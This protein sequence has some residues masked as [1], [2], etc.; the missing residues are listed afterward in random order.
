MDEELLDPK[1]LESE[2][3]R[4]CGGEEGGHIPFQY[5]NHVYTV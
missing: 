2:A 1:H 3:N 4:D 5:L